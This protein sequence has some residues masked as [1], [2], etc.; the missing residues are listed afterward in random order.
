MDPEFA[1][2]FGK[3]FQKIQINLPFSIEV[4]SLIDQLEEIDDDRFTID[5]QWDAESCRISLADSNSFLEVFSESIHL[6]STL[7]QETECLVHGVV[8]YQT[9]LESAL[10]FST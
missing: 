6:G 7:S 8:E 10:S 2:V 4:D 1:Q 5:Y 9:V 3:R